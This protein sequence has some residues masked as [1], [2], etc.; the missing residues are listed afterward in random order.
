MS[1]MAEN[2]SVIMAERPGAALQGLAF[3]LIGVV[4]FGLTLPFTRLAVAD[5][6]PFFVAIGRAVVA[7]GL[8][9]IVLLV[10]RPE[11]P[12]RADAMRFIRY[13]LGVVIGFPLFATLAMTTATAAHGGVVLAVLPLATA[14]AGVILAGERP[15][16]GFW[17]SA[18]GGGL[19]VALYVWFARGGI[20]GTEYADLYLLAAIV[21]A[22]FGYTDGGLLARK[23]GG[24]QTIS[25]ALI[26]SA[27][28]MIALLWGLGIGPNPD[29]SVSAWVGFG[30]VSVFSMYL[31]FFAWN[32]GL[33]LGGIARV[34]QLLLFQTFVT[35]AASAAIL[36]ERVGWLE[37]GFAI[38][39]IVWV[40]VSWRMR[41][42]VAR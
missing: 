31:G 42:A 6:D 11:V 21:S 20:V 3:G 26:F 36:G 40:G 13:S 19:T 30:Y 12:L 18:V 29:A 27:P 32:L 14:V 41:I 28:F 24:W 38:G 33:A 25:W 23:Y 7:A 34:G 5:L 15:S 35:L 4:I 37:L 17:L 39:V 9:S 22:A 10:W 1:E 16:V 8:A 2:R